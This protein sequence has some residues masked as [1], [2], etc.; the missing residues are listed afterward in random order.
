VA[1]PWACYRESVDVVFHPKFTLPLLAPCK[2]V[3]VVHGADWFVPEQAQFYRRLDICYIKT[4]MPLYF[5]K[6]ALVLSVS[7]LTT[8]GFCMAL[9]LPAGKIETVYFAP[10]R[11][12][13]PVT[14]ERVLRDVR[15]RY[16]LPERFVFTLTK[17]GGDRRK[18][19]GQV[20]RAYAR[21]YARAKQRSRTDRP[22]ELVVG[23]EGCD[24]LRERYGIPADGWGASVR[25]PGWIAQEDLPAVYSL[26]SVYL[27]PS[28]L[29][30]FPI[31]V[32]EAMA[33]GT[34][35][36]TSNTNGLQEIAGNG[37][38][39]V[40]P[41]NDREIAAALDRVL[42]DASLQR[43]LGERGLK[44]SRRYNWDKCAAETL[45]A[46]E[47]AGKSSGGKKRDVCEG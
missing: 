19:F 21:Y 27:Y 44:R 25:F 24:C 23:G 38:L 10:A 1:I 7:Q 14:D 34:P 45:Q 42:G 8:D 5:R 9:G 28:N 46:L 40:D 29:E 3:M 4:V 22:H 41:E 39:L 13:G 32:T 26:A 36:I 37:A 20:V 35:V 16:R 33:C 6:A 17:V 15:D 30:A 2:A 18:N 31:P 11:H 43:A 47:R 12:F